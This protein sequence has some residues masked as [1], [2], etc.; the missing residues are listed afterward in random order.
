MLL[1]LDA[2]ADDCRHGHARAVADSR[3]ND[4]LPAASQHA[5]LVGDDLFQLLDPL[6]Q[7]GQDIALSPRSVRV[8]C[9]L[10]IPPVGLAPVHGMLDARRDALQRRYKRLARGCLWEHPPRRGVVLDDG[11]PVAVGGLVHAVDGAAGKVFVLVQE[12]DGVGV[13]L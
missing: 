12:D 1:V 8:L 13:R 7:I 11:L 6:P 10:V 3:Q 4:P 9:L 2:Q 5:H